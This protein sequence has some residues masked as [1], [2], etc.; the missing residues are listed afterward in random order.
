M[1]IR[2][3]T[4]SCARP[5][6]G[7]PAILRSTD[8]LARI[9]GDEFAVIAPGSHG[10]GAPRMGEAIAQRDR[11]STSRTR[12]PPPPSASVGGAVFPEDG[13]DVGA[14]IRSA[15]RRMLE[16]KRSGDRRAVPVA[17]RGRLEHAEQLGHSADQEPLLVDFDPGPGGGGE[18]DVVAGLDRHLDPGARPPVQAGPDREHD[19]LLGRRLVGAGR[20]HQP[21]APH[22]VLIQ[23][24]DHDLV[25][26]R[27]QLVADR[28]GRVGRCA[29]PTA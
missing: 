10:E 24:L 26:E 28:L 2:S 18:D 16:S 25:E 23:L 7:S 27:P 15:D 19:P 9:G 14:L 3:A 22:P 20:D 5:P 1:A 12:P 4:R 13:E 17:Q 6:S 8:L 11:P 21:R 29:V